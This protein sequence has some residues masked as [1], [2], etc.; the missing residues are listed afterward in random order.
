MKEAFG[1]QR[2]VRSLNVSDKQEPIIRFETPPGKQA[3]ADWTV[4]RGGKSPICAFVMVLGY[5]RM[6][7]VVFTEDMRQETW[8]RCHEKAFAYFGGVPETI[9]YDNLKSVV[10]QRDRYGKGQHGFNDAFLDFS[11]GRFIPKLCRPYRAQTKGKVERFNRYLKQSFYLPLKTALKR[12]GIPI[13]V[14]LLNSH[15]HRWMEMAN[16]RVHATTKERP[17]DRFEQQERAHLAPWR[18]VAKVA[19]PVAS[20]A[21]TIAKKANVT[22]TTKLDAYEKILEN[23]HACA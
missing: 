9:L 11:K 1:L 14:T 17:V 13:D 12:S 15:L 5:S 10:I 7:Y 21:T 8:Q 19:E 3:Q 18:P 6:A 2:Y 16:Q 20:I 23:A 22:Y 4:I